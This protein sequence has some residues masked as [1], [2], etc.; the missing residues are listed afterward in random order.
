M[1]FPSLTVA[2]PSAGF[3]NRVAAVG[4]VEASSE[5]ISMGSHL[6]GVVEKVWVTVGQSVKAGDPMVKLDTR[7]LDAM[8]AERHAELAAAGG[9]CGHGARHAR[10]RRGPACRMCSG[11]CV[12]PNRCPIREASVSKN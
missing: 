10:G 5:N 7:A 4:L 3:P 2:P 6:S 11:R 1:N 12:L 8:H 9:G